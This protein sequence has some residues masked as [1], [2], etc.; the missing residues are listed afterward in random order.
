LI[1]EAIFNRR[2]ERKKISNDFSSLNT[3]KERERKGLQR[4]RKRKKREQLSERKRQTLSERKRLRKSERDLQREI[5][6]ESE[7]GLQR[8]R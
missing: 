3:E 8:E 5:W 4:G 1:L 2:R 6:I 7:K